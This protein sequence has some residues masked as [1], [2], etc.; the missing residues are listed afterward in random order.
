MSYDIVCRYRVQQSM[1]RFCES[2]RGHSKNL[3]DFEKKNMLPLTKEEI[4]LHQDAKTCC[5]CGRRIS[6]KLS[7]IEIMESYRLLPLY[8]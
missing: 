2:F 7:K 4:K 3:I 6:R 8:R 1:K 5:I